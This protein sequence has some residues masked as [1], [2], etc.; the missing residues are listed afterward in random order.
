MNSSEP[1]ALRNTILIL[2]PLLRDQKQLLSIAR[3]ANIESLNYV[4][5]EGKKVLRDFIETIQTNEQDLPLPVIEEMSAW[6]VSDT[7]SRLRFA[8]RLRYS[9]G[10]P[11]QPETESSSGED[12]ADMRELPN[13]TYS[14]LKDLLRTL[15]PDEKKD[16]IGRLLGD[17]PI[18]DQASVI[19]RYTRADSG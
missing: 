8:P 15:S 16:V 6:M 14:L 10:L 5:N 7:D 9:P 17:L 11:T 4:S 12:T 3:L 2:L 18:L 13:S 1:D 19:E